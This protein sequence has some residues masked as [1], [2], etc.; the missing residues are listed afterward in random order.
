MQRLVGPMT[1]HER[2][3]RLAAF[4]TGCLGV[5]TPAKAGSRL[6][7]MGSAGREDFAQVLQHME[8][9]SKQRAAKLS[10]V[11]LGALSDSK[12][13]SQALQCSATFEQALCEACGTPT[14]RSAELFDQL[15]HDTSGKV[16][17]VSVF[18]MEAAASTGHGYSAGASKPSATVQLPAEYVENPVDLPASSLEQ[19]AAA[20]DRLLGSFEETGWLSDLSAVNT[21]RAAFI[22]SEQTTMDV[23]F[24]L[25][26]AL[27]KR[28]GCKRPA[29]SKTALR[30]I[31]ELAEGSRTDG[32]SCWHEA[33][34]DV[35]G[36]CLA[37][38][39]VTKAAARLAEETLDAVLR[40]VS[41][42]ATP[43]GNP[44]TALQAVAACLES[45]ISP[46]GSRAPNSTAIAA[47]LRCTVPLLSSLAPACSSSMPDAR[48]AAEAMVASC[49][50]L[51][52][53]R[54]LASVHSE[55]RSVIR[56]LLPC[57][58]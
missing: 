40:R 49:E 6:G 37:A 50:A 27:A 15:P 43:E 13:Q 8:A 26:S 51:L 1:H 41:A 3:A 19:E 36:G 12:D 35:L 14:I 32:T 46:S 56:E 21:L 4:A 5:P 9:L 31:M 18:S 24:S 47:A 28:C 20:K 33:A 29:L 53:N 2:G 11:G 22:A 10:G 48:A 57:L 7:L 17:L 45:E 39:R 38:I 23:S 30:A 42:D 58:K 54:K 44:G 16:D 34:G 25:L 55:A 52:G